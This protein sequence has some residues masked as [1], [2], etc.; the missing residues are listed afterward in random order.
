MDDFLSLILYA[1]LGVLAIFIIVRIVKAASRTVDKEQRAGRQPAQIKL[2]MTTL[3][4][5]TALGLPEARADL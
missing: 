3:E 5:E 4:V 2:G 1:L